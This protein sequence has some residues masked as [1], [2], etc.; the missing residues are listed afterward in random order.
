[1]IPKSQSQK[2]RQASVAGEEQIPARAHLIK[3]SRRVNIRHVQRGGEMGEGDKNCADGI[4]QGFAFEHEWDPARFIEENAGQN[5]DEDKHSLIEDKVDVYGGDI[6][7]Q[8]VGNGIA[9]V[10][11]GV[12]VGIVGPEHSCS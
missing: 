5:G 10:N 9:R 3:K 2:K 8:E 11:Y 12:G 7:E 4:E 6:V 1:M